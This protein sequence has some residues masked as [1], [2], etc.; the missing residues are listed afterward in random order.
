MYEVIWFTSEG[1]EHS[2]IVLGYEKA[3]FVAYIQEGL[4]GGWILDYSIEY[5]GEEE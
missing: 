4:R 5:I 1:R 2:R 3:D